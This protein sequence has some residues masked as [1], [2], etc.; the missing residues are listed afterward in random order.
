MDAKGSR[1][2][3]MNAG[4][5]ESLADLLDRARPES[6][7][8]RILTVAYW[9]EA[10]NGGGDWTSQSLNDE[11]KQLGEG[12]PNITDALSRLMSKKPALIRQT[13]KSGRTPQARKRYALTSAGRSQVDGPRLL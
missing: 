2:P 13:R 3:E 6:R 9:L 4:Q 12:V 5:P 7:A 10:S 8:D 1:D 11:L